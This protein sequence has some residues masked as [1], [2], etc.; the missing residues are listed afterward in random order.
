LDK[1]SFAD[2]GIHKDLMRSLTDHHRCT[3]VEFIELMACR[4]GELL[5]HGC[6]LVV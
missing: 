4:L 6:C 2:L 5:N 3:V 1:I